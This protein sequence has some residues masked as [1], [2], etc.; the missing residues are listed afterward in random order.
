MRPAGPAT[1]YL[2]MT[3]EKAEEIRREYFSGGVTQTQLASR[4]GL[5]QGT[6]SRIVSGR[7][8]Q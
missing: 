1:R 2:D 6:V 8:W 5:R 4:Y 3:R 7:V